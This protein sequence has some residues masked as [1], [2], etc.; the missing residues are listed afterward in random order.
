MMDTSRIVEAR[1][2]EAEG[3]RIGHILTEV[4]E[5]VESKIIARYLFSATGKTKLPS[6]EMRG[7]I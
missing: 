6:N 7:K 1:I 2:V 5:K 4:G 3:V